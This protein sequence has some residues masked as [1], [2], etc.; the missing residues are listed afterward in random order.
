MADQIDMNGLS[1]NE[2]QPP[3]NGLNARSTYIPPHMRSSN[4]VSP[5]DAPVFQG[6]LK[7]SVWSGSAR[8]VPDS[9]L[10]YMKC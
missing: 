3:P 9:D 7:S 2:S 8:F 10:P 6:D 4:G 5:M 1:L